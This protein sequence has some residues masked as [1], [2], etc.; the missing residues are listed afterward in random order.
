MRCHH[1]LLILKSLPLSIIVTFRMIIPILLIFIVSTVITPV[2]SILTLGFSGLIVTPATL[3]FI[4]LY[5]THI[6]LELL[7]KRGLID[8]WVM[9][10]YSV[11]FGLFIGLVKLA[12]LFVIQYLSIFAAQQ[13][14]G[15]DVSLRSLQSTDEAVQNAFV[16]NAVSLWA[17]FSLIFLSS[18]QALFAIPLAAAAN[19]ARQKSGSS[20]FLE[21]FGKSFLPLFVVA[22]ITLFLQ[23]VFRIFA[24]FAFFFG[25]FVFQIAVLIDL[26]ADRMSENGLAGLAELFALID[27]TA[28]AL[29]LGSLL[30]V[31]WLKAWVW[32]IAALAFQKQDEAAT[33]HAV[34]SNRRPA[35]PSQDLRDLRKSR[36]NRTRAE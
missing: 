32:S 7:G 16:L 5:G 1:L 34:Q 9:I 26:A 4:T 8:W 24:V 30:A 33:K 28:T 3:T 17:V 35:I 27:P 12:G 31:L 21:G 19:N 29:S 13:H 6:A 14:L 36:E 18:I 25:T 20:E 15:L 22:I 23:F 11:T 2:L 10:T